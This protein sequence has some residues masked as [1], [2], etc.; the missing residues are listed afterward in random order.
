LLDPF[1]IALGEGQCDHA[2]VGSTHD[3]AQRAD[4][5]M[6]EQQA[7]RLRLIV[8]RYARECAAGDRSAR[9]P[10]RAHIVDAEH[11]YTIA[12]E[13][14]GRPGE[15]RPPAR[16]RLLQIEYA[17]MRRDAAQGQHDGGASATGQTPAEPQRLDAAAMMQRKSRAPMQYVLDRGRARARAIGLRA[18]I[19][20]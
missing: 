2:A 12:V 8:A 9:L 7:Q 16:A 10:A 3:G 1:R 17:P 19:R 13:R 11:A 18:Q 14:R 5:K 15:L 6:I 4:M 20:V